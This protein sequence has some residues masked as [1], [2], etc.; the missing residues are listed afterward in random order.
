MAQPSPSGCQVARGGAEHDRRF[1]GI[2]SPAPGADFQGAHH[3]SAQ[4]TARDDLVAFILSG[5][6]EAKGDIELASHVVFGVVR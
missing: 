3:H 4:G 1:M 6:D 5:L 2:T